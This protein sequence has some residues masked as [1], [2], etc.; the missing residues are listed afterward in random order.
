M[1]KIIA[2]SGLIKKPALKI[3]KVII[4]C[5]ISLS[6]GKKSFPITNAKCPNK[7]KSYHSKVLPIMLAIIVFFIATPIR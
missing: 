3:P 7:A 5:I 6:L 2:P 4:I 1:P